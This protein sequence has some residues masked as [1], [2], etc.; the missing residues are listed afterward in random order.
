MSSG[1]AASSPAGA[2]ARPVVFDVALA[3]EV[4]DVLARVRALIA[5]DLGA[6]A[7]ADR[8]LREWSGGHRRTFDAARGVHE[9]ALVAVAEGVA[10]DLA[11]LR[12]ARAEAVDLRS[13]GDAAA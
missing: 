12:A 7:A 3:D 1:W 2:S 4:G 10:R 6:R 11:R 9:R 5:A 13:G 8:H